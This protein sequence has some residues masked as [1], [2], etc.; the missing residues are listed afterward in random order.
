VRRSAFNWHRCI[1]APRPKRCARGGN[2]DTPR[3]GALTI[4]AGARSRLRPPL[5]H[6]ERVREE[7]G[8]GD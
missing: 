6:P 3:T 2:P 5:W 1:V 8:S 4:G 7:R